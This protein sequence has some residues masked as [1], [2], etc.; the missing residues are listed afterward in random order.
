MAT[1]VILVR[2][3]KVHGA[4]LPFGTTRR[5]A[6]QFGHALIHRHPHGQGLAVRAITGND[7]IVLTAQGQGADCHRLLAGVQVQKAADLTTG[8]ILLERR[9]LEPPDP[10]HLTQKMNLFRRF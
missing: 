10:Q 7:V 9:L 3:E 1:P 6:E 4:A 5:P 8:L 2:R